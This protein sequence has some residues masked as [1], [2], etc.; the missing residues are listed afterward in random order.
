MAAGA[1]PVKGG[2]GVRNAM[3]NSA[4]RSI[5]DEGCVC[6]RGAKASGVAL[7]LVL[8]LLMPACQAWGGRRTESRLG[9]F[10]YRK[11]DNGILICAPHGT[12]DRRTDEIA[13]AAARKLGAGYVVARGFTPGGVRINVNRPTEGAGMSSSREPRTRRSREVYEDYA[14]LVRKAAGGERLRLYVEVHGNSSPLSAFKIELATTGIGRAEARELKDAFSGIIQGVRRKAP[15]YPRLALMVEPIDTLFFSSGGVK[16]FG[17]M[18]DPLVPRALHFELPASVRTSRMTG[19]TADLVAAI[20]AAAA[21][22]SADGG[23]GYD[24]RERFTPRRWQ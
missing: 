24:Q 1:L 16:T 23:K 18:A 12:Y 22:R 6:A 4:S 13:I 20:V 19:A 7:L 15:L 14:E 11:T 2:D 8:A 10:D 9:A 17:I 5:Y 3:T 21:G